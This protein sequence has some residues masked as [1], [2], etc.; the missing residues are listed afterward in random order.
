MPVLWVL[1]AMQSSRNRAGVRRLCPLGRSYNIDL[2]ASL[3]RW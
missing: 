3:K 1:A 2:S